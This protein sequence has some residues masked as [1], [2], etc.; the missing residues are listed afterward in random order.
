MPGIQLSTTFE[1]SPDGTYAAGYEYIRNGNPNRQA[2]EVAMA[3]L[4]GGSTAIAFASGMA[5]TMAV[6]QSLAPGDH[7]LAPLDA[8]FG[9]AKLLTTHFKPWGLAVSF[10]D[11][12][13]PR[14]V[15]SAARPGTRLIWAET[16]SNPTIA[17]TDL[18]AIGEVARS[19]GAFTVCDNTWATPFLQ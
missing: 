3:R 14:A 18:A 4:E 7:V 11:M 16:P 15:R 17:V 1:R 8:Y 12:T 13:D 2:L 9:T 6:F 5:A 19:V 10:V